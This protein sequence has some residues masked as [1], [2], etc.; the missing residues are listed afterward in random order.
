MAK[1]M[2][3]VSFCAYACAGA[4]TIV[5][6]VLVADL[7]IDTLF[8]IMM[9]MMIYWGRNPELWSAAGGLIF[10]IIFTCCRQS[11]NAAFFRT[12]EITN[13]MK[14]PRHTGD[15]VE[16]VTPTPSKLKDG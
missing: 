8:A 10:T 12:E 13:T 11:V 6:F 7:L 4:F 2:A 5:P 3:P 1:A 16:M 15:Y 9:G 14:K